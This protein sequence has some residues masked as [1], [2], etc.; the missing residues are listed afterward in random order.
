VG[1]AWSVEH[2]LLDLATLGIVGLDRDTLT[3]VLKEE[4]RRS[5]PLVPGL[6]VAVLLAELDVTLVVSLPVHGSPVQA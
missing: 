2:L 3:G 6:L 5:G 4:D 1:Q